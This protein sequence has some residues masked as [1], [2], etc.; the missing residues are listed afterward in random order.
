V[1][2]FTAF[3][4]VGLMFLTVWCFADFPRHTVTH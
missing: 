1:M 4:F 3:F 2:A